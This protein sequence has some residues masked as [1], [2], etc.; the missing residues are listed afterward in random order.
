MT[1]K[2]QI[3]YRQIPIIVLYSIFDKLYPLL[4]IIFVYI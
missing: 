4:Y 3:I 1:K 2:K